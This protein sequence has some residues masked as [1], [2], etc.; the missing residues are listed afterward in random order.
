MILHI[1]RD[2]FYASVEER[3]NPSLVGTAVIVGGTA[4][5]RSLVAAANYAARKNYVSGT[6]PRLGV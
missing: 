1:D 6:M 2:A 3:E 4:E 5:C